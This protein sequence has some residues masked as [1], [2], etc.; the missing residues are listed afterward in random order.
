MVFFNLANAFGSVPHS[1]LWKTFSYVHVTEKM[2]SLV[3]AN[4]EDIQLC[5]PTS[6]GMLGC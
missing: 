4:F 1:Q 5:S 2:S 3:R 6:D